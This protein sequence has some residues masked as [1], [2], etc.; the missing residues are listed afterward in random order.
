M[1]VVDGSTG[2]AGGASAQG[3]GAGDGAGKGDGAGVAAGRSVSSTLMA[4][5]LLLP[6]PGAVTSTDCNSA[7][8]PS[9]MPPAASTRRGS[10]GRSLWGTAA[11]V[12][13]CRIPTKPVTPIPAYLSR[14]LPPTLLL[15]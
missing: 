1:P 6:G 4:W 9:R 5:G 14:G 15:H 2:S 12:E 10:F 8:A 7:A 3:D 11:G 13:C